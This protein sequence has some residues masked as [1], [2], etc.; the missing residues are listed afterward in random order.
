MSWLKTRYE[1]GL[2]AAM[3]RPSRT[4]GIGIAAF[5]VAIGSF[6]TLGQE[7]LPQLD[8]G[9]VL[10]QAFRVPGTSVDQSQAMQ[11]EIESNRRPRAGGAVRIFKDR[12]CRTCLG[13]DA[14]ERFGHVRDPEAPQRLARSAPC[15]VRIG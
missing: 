10:I 9:D 3:R 4:L 1:P 6:A 14:N 7:F 13:P 12:H 11:L 8:E 15:E 2:N 5:V